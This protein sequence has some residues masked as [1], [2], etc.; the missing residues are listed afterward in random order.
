ML[1]L[2][3]QVFKQTLMA[4]AIVL[5]LFTV[6]TQPAFAI[7]RLTNT[8]INDAIHYGL[9]NR[10]MGLNFFLSRN[11]IEGP[12]GALLN[13]YTPYMEI[14]RSVVHRK[15]DST[16]TTPEN[17]LKV[18][19]KCIEDVHYIYHH[20]TVKF[21]ISLYGDSLKFAKGYFARIEGVGKGR[22]ITL[23][24]I[25]SV[26]NMATKEEGAKFKPYS[27]ILNFHYKFEDIAQ[28][29]NFKLILWGKDLPTI[30]FPINTKELI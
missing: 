14:A 6:V 5:T 26:T 28:L 1:F 19:K 23:R 18:R 17:V 2:Y 10:E 24:P 25:K 12:N 8:M 7:K 22:K 4:L 21:N 13:V 15:L 11:W 27:A 9:V 20:Q 29:D 3:R 16:E 30:E